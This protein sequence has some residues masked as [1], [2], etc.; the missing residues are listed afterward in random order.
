VMKCG[1]SIAP[2]AVWS[3]FAGRATM[4]AIQS[5]IDPLSRQPA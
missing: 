4:N 5:M 2:G 3:M 1:G